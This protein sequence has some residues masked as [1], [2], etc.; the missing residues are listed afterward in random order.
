MK[1]I[2]PLPGIVLSVIVALLACWLESLLPIHLIGCYAYQRTDTV[3][4]PIFTIAISNAIGM[5]F[6]ALYFGF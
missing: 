5:V 3:W 6:Y 1:I 2:N 4:G